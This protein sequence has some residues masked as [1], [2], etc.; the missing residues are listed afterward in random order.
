MSEVFDT[1]IVAQRAVLPEGERSCTVALSG[2]RVATVEAHGR[3]LPAKATVVLEDDVVL[4]PGLVDTHVHV[5]EP[6]NQDWEGF[7]TATWAAAAGGITT[8]VDMPLDSVPAT[9]NVAALDA[10]LDAARGKCYVDVGFWGGVVPG[11]VA[12]LIPLYGA[13]VLGFK[14]FLIDSGS[15]HFLPV[16]VAELAQALEVLSRIKAP[17][18]VHAESAEVASALPCV[19]SPRYEDYLR[20]R[21]RGLENLAV[22]Q[23]IEVARK[24]GGRVHVCHLSSS[25]AVPMLRSAQAESVQVTAETCPHYLALRS[26]DIADGMT[27]AKCSPP[28][29]EGQNQDLLWDALREGVIRIVVSDHSPCLPAMKFPPDGDFC[30]AWSGVS[31]LQLSLSVVWAQAQARGF[32]LGDIVGW[33]A[34]EPARLAGLEHKGSIAVGKDADFC[35]FAA[36]EPFRVS[37]GLV[38]H[39]HPFTPYDGQVLLGVVRET[40][41]RGERVVQSSRRGQLLL[42]GGRR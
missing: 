42:R 17:L 40:W 15:E 26:E 23:V 31:S 30:A 9:V 28:V 27:S 22:A 19:H 20:S 39:R 2:G 18:L 14:C 34:A 24:V 21:P 4:L 41:L 37:P 5:C 11:N 33:M 1:V 6:G 36:Q 25:D 12:D 16:S 29:R 10:K 13:G 7:V 3:R 35:M 32:S 8:L 38:K